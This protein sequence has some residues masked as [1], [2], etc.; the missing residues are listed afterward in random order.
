MNIVYLNDVVKGILVPSR[1]T[2]TGTEIYNVLYWRI[3]AIK[4]SIWGLSRYE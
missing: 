4:G 1:Y 2:Y 3:V